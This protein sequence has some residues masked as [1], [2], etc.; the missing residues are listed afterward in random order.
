MNPLIWL[1]T[2]PRA[3]VSILGG[4]LMFA[5]VLALLPR[6]PWTLIV[7]G[8]AC[9]FGVVVSCMPDDFGPP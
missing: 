1:K 8:A 4:G 5:G 3:A 7:V 2:H 6:S 9:L